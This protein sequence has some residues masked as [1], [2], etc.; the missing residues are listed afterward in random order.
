MEQNPFSVAIAYANVTKWFGETMETLSDHDKNV[1]GT[2]I[3]RIPTFSARVPMETP[4]DDPLTKRASELLALVSEASNE[5]DHDR[6]L[7]DEL[8]KHLD[9]PL[10]VQRL[11]AK[12]VEE[13]WLCGVVGFIDS[14]TGQGR[15]E[16]IHLRTEGLRPDK[17][18]HKEKSDSRRILEEFAS[19]FKGIYRENDRLEVRSVHRYNQTVWYGKHGI[20]AEHPKEVTYG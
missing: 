10:P 12:R 14:Y 9:E 8:N 2:L 16:P 5:D 18:K 3:A 15:E 7:L 13:A 17:K 19:A 20:Y 1:I 11:Y 4:P 6:I